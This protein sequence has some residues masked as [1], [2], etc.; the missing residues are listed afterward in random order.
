MFDSRF[1]PHQIHDGPT[2]AS[3]LIGSYCHSEQIISL[4]S[5]SN[6]VFIRFVSDINTNGRGFEL[7]FSESKFAEKA[8]SARISCR[9]IF[10]VFA[11]FYVYIVRVFF[12]RL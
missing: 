11:V 12:H 2:A 5:T 6:V 3:H 4:E 8:V 9:W 10:L 1:F 7:K